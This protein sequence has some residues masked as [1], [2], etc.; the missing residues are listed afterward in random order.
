MVTKILKQKHDSLYLILQLLVVFVKAIFKIS[1]LFQNKAK[2][3]STMW[4]FLKRIKKVSYRDFL[5]KRLKSLALLSSWIH[6][7]FLR[8]SKRLNL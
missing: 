6:S 2:K 7:I 8:E 3:N 5:L 4:S 1:G